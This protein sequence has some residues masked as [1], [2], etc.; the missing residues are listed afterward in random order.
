M[1]CL[2]SLKAQLLTCSTVVSGSRS[3]SLQTC[4]GYDR[5]LLAQADVINLRRR[6]AM[7]NDVKRR[8]CACTN[9]CTNAHVRIVDVHVRTHRG[10]FAVYRNLFS[11]LRKDRKFRNHFLWILIWYL[12]VVSTSGVMLCGNSYEHPYAMTSISAPALVAAYGLVG[13][14]SDAAHCLI[15]EGFPRTLHPCK[16]VGIARLS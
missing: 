2:R 14:R 11:A 15:P 1:K 7:E 6:P 3:R 10:A 4:D 13:V 16:R 9:A 12:N 5:L 8:R